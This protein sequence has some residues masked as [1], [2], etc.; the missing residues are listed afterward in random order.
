MTEVGGRGSEAGGGFVT[1]VLLFG[2]V[3]RRAGLGSHAGRMPDALQ[4]IDAVGV[5]SRA[6]VKAALRALMV[7][8]HEDIARFDAA[9][10]LFWR[11]QD[12]GGGG[13]PLFSLGERPRV[14][15]S[16]K[17]T[18]SIEAASEAGGPSS[19]PTSLAV[20]AYSASDLSRTKDFA[21]FSP[22]ELAR[23]E[24]VLRDL[25]WDLG[26]RRT[27]RWRAG[28]RGVVDLR[29]I[30]ARNLRLGGELVEVPRR[31][32]VEKPRPLVLIADVSGSMERYSRMLLHFIAGVM[33]GPARVEAFV[34]ATRLTRLTR[35]ARDRRF[36]SSAQRMIRDVQDW[37][38]GTRIGDA[39]RAFSVRWAR[40]VMR[41]GPA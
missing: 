27:R 9:F 13:L 10:D 29:R 14:V 25:A 32:R 41:N 5:T 38:G 11:A 22:G 16:P 15:V 36:G 21:D 39:L 33:R 17:G 6:D 31:A 20:G 4:A 2:E 24:S 19:A 26:R 35:A 30:V 7:H 34:F 37:G 28:T 8:R 23:A 1:N 3:L 18:V 40:R 12:S